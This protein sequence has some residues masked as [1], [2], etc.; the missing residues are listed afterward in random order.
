[1][2]LM[3]GGQLIFWHQLNL[4]VWRGSVDVDGIPF[5]P[6]SAFSGLI[7]ILGIEISTHFQYMLAI[8]LV[9]YHTI[10]VY[11]VDTSWYQPDH[12]KQGDRERERRRLSKRRQ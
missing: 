12:C 2:M 1:M 10:Q 7:L 5:C 8:G 9:G 11:R 3:A 6:T 4:V